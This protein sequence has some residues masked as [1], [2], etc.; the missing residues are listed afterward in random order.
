LQNPVTPTNERYGVLDLG[1]NTFS[2]LVVEKS[3]DSFKSLNKTKIPV[4]IGKNGFENK[5]IQEDAFNRGIL[6]IEELLE[7][8]N[9]YKCNYIKG[10][11]T[12][13]LRTA[14]NAVDFTKKAKDLFNLEIEIISGLREAEL[15]Y[16]GVKLSGALTKEPALIIDIGG[17]SVEFII[18][19]NTKCFWKASL[20]IGVARILENFK[21]SEQIQENELK[22]IHQFL[23]RETITLNQAFRKYLPKKLIGASGSFDS[24][25]EMISQKEKLA[26]N[27]D[28]VNEID[29]EKF[30][31]I[32]K[33][34]L[35]STREEREKIPGLIPMRIDYIVLASI[36]V[37]FVLNKNHI[38]NLY[39]SA[40]SLKE[41]V[42]AEF[43]KQEV[44]VKS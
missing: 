8:A 11:A 26:A 37:R 24:F 5:E 13:A 22:L 38:S 21:P 2:L 41:G 25:I 27:T 35:A 31:S 17:G 14:K 1:S 6:A 42:I 40:Y 7:H 23:D 16:E 19:N 34:I 30:A 39:Q 12:S 33:E 3:G 10:F 32:H 36:I 43:L 20:P 9:I 18:A 44:W 15:I 4:K 29:L 28:L